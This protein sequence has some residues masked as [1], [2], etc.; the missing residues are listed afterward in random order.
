[1]EPR[2]FCYWLQGYMEVRNPQVIDAKEVAIIK[3]HLDLVFNK[4]TTSSSVGYCELKSSSESEPKIPNL[5]FDNND[6]DGYDYLSTKY[7]GS[8]SERLC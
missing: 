8:T 5:N 1:M 4:V 2:D 3:E 7:T 6:A